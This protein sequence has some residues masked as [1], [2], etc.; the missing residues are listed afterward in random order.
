MACMMDVVVVGPCGAGK[1]TLVDALITRGYAARV[2]AQEHSIVRDLWRHGGHP[3]A[4]VMLEAEPATIA[5]RRH[6]E[7]PA[8][9]YAKQFQ[10]LA[11]ARAHA[12]LLIATDQVQAEEVTRQ[13]I[14]FLRAAGISPL[15]QP[16]QEQA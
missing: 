13:V 15:L 3:A 4:L 6:A 12:D 11:A 16:G 1:T 10:R 9:L 5:A 8:W 14:A 7:F 2:V